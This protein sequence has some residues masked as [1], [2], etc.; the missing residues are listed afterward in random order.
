MDLPAHIPDNISEVLVRIVRFTELRR[1][2][3]RRNIESTNAPGYRPQDLP[4]REFAEVLN[5]AIVEHL[6]NR[7]L[8]FRDTPNIRFGANSV[9]EVRPVFDESARVLLGASRNDYLEQQFDKL[10]ENSLNR[11][12]AEELLRQNCGAA[13]DS[14]DADLDEVMAAEETSEDSSSRRKTTS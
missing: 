1:A 5:S 8:L 9:M 11:N 3:L 12:V 7:R 4:V 14:P 2:I 10:L 6:Q 13:A